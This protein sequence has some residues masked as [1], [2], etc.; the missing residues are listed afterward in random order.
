M[1]RENV[2]LLLCTKVRKSQKIRLRF[3]IKNQ[4]RKTSFCHSGLHLSWWMQNN[5]GSKL[6]LWSITLWI[7][8]CDIWKQLKIAL[9]FFSSCYRFKCQKELFFPLIQD[10]CILH[11]TVNSKK[12][13]PRTN[14]AW[15]MSTLHEKATD[16]G[17]T[18][19]K[20]STSWYCHV[21]CPRTCANLCLHFVLHNQRNIPCNLWAMALSKFEIEFTTLKDYIVHWP[22]HLLRPHIG[23][24]R[25]N[26]EKAI[27]Q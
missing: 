1:Y 4:L 11:I 8:L 17:L 10:R 9:P 16:L 15:L 12:R 14:Y 20:Y 13:R 18:Q 24:Y 19:R 21:I 27:S 6:I 23:H 2:W 26:R 3:Q 7:R 5:N 22:F 25:R